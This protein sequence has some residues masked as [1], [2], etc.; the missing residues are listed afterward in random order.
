MPCFKGTQSAKKRQFSDIKALATT[1]FALGLWILEPECF[2]QA[3]FDKI[4]NRA[5]NQD[6]AIPIHNDLNT[7]GLEN[8]II[9]QDFISIIDHVREART[10]GFL[11]ADPQTETC[12]TLQQMG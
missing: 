5:V 11:D 4:H 8:G 1:A 3:L 10:A 7:A 12:A 6:E 2:V 9:R